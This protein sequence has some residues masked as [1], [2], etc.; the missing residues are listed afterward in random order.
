M[1]VHICCSVDSHY[2]LSELQKVYPDEKL[3]GFFYNPNIHPKAEHDLRLL[4]VKRS[5]EMLGI[6]LIE[7]KYDDW[8]WSEEVRGLEDEP[9]KGARCNVCFDVRL[10]ES[11]KLSKNLNQKSF[12]TTLLSSPM[13]TQEILFAQG[14]KIAQEYDLDFI[15]IDVRSNGG[16]QKQ[17]ELSKKDNLYRQNYCG[18]KFALQKQRA[19]QE[20]F[21]LEFISPLNQQVM[22]ASI[23]YRNAVFALRNELESEKKDYLLTQQ[24]QLVWRCLNAKL[25]RFAEVIPCH[26]LVHSSSKKNVRL[27]SLIWGRPKHLEDVLKRGKIGYSRRDETLMVTLSALNEIMLTNYQGI[28]DLLENPLPYP[29]ELILRSKIT[30]FHSLCPIVVVENELSEDLRLDITS[31]FQEE[32]VFEIVE[33]W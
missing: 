13:K 2:F 29:Q 26:I 27:G 25:E 23:E 19:K 7:G 20:K 31:L 10:L 30:H 33:F 9:E 8:T 24:N 18:C 3:I 12:T 15:K 21:P 14:D 4:D 6:Q 5:C 32:R 1:L 16:T 11:A 22:P 17:N 28:Q